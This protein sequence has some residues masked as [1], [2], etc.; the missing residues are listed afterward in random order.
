[1]FEVTVQ[2]LT[3]I[4]Y[5]F[6]LF[7]LFCLCCLMVFLMIIAWDFRKSSQKSKYAKHQTAGEITDKDAP[8]ARTFLA[9]VAEIEARQK[10]SK[11][12]E[13]LRNAANRGKPLSRV[14]L[15]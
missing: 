14:A 6:V 11:E 1:M 15:Q 13:E 10:R 7:F 12:L 8:N 9:E 4:G 3:L 5:M 2:A